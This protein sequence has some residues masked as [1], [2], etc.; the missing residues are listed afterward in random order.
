MIHLDSVISWI[1]TFFIMQY[2]SGC[3]ENVKE[4]V[5]IERRKGKIF[6]DI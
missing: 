3:D 2:A 1:Y 5:I 6:I 4:V